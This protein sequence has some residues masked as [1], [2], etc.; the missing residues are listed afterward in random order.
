MDLKSKTIEELKTLA[1]EA[2]D[3][4]ES[5]EPIMSDAEYDE[6]RQF[7]GDENNANIGSKSKSSEYTVKHVYIMGSLDKVHTI[8]NTEQDDPNYGKINFDEPVYT[9]DKHKSVVLIKEINNHITKADNAKSIETTPKLDGCS[10]SLQVTKDSSSPSGI[11]MTCA[12]RGDG[13]YGSD[14]LAYIMNSHFS[15]NFS[16][17]KEATYSLLNE[18]YDTFV[19]RGEAEIKNSVYNK[20]YADKFKNPRV[21]VSGNLSHEIDE[22]EPDHNEH[23]E[24]LDDIDYLCYDYRRVNSKTLDY[25]E[26][27]WMNE[28]DPS[29]SLMS[30]FKHLGQRPD[31]S[32]CKII[33]L[34][35][36]KLDSQS[37][38]DIYKFYSDYRMVS[39]YALDGI[40]IKP[41][42]Q[43]RLH[44]ISRKRPDDMIAVK[45]ITE[46]MK[47]VIEDIVWKVGQSGE[48]FPRCVLKP[49]YYDG[50]E[51]K[52]A[53]LHGY[54]YIIQNSCGIGSD[55]SMVM[56][57]DIVPGV[58]NVLSHGE[59]K[60]PD[61][62]TE[63][64]YI[65]DSD[66]PHLYKVFSGNELYKHMFITSPKALEINGIKEKTAERIWNEVN[67]SYKNR[68]GN[69]LTNVMQLMDDDSYKMLKEILGDSKS[70]NNYISCLQRY[71]EN[72]NL[73][74][75]I[76]GLCFDGCGHKVS[77]ICARILS[78]LDYDLT[79]IPE[80]AYSW[81]LD[82]DSEKYRK[83]ESYMKYLNI[84]FMKESEK[85]EVSEGKTPIIMTGNPSECTD[86]STKKEWI[87]A[88]PQYIETSKWSD[89]KILFTND[90]DSIT[91]KMKKAAK[92]NIEI[93]QYFD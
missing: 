63:I 84:G 67:E 49:V 16:D 52:M 3:A 25:Q 59:I 43:C 19:I 22:F 28:D 12:T 27:S 85:S 20:K 18:E 17:L 79:S 45:F 72:M 42:C 93:R 81:T 48:C 13:N 39:D 58:D 80:K 40:V 34:V 83:V 7:I 66:I 87:K 10:W 54:S 36:G 78:G 31:L 44:N 55:V 74:D 21:F 57:G 92:N 26:I 60:L 32:A 4:Y 24:M 88:H 9:N 73:E 15:E 89:C 11:S 8:K 64:K 1:D 37:L 46:Q 61:F 5:G 30:K 23:M 6:I 41:T 29:Y 14:I 56:N 86:Y 69:E 77:N 71:K 50:K 82:N 33:P 70:T 51:I 35:E 47:S 62:D 65:G 75:L 68:T 2:C 53:S 76:R 90:L 38:K 91:S